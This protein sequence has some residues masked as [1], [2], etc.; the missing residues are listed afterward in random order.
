MN[1]KAITA[2]VVGLVIGFILG[3]FVARGPGNSDATTPSNVAS[4]NGAEMPEGHP[5][6]EVIRKLAEL[7]SRATSNPQ[8][9]EVR[10]FLGNFYYDIGRYDGAIRWYEEALELDPTDVNVSTDLGT[11]YL[12]VGNTDRAIEVYKKSLSL[13]PNHPQTLQNLGIAYSNIEKF[14]EAAETWNRLIENHPEHP[15]IGRLKEQIEEARQ[16][17]QGKL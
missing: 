11:S 8:D 9:R 2:G 4:T 5:P 16:R 14:A 13:Q 3:F 1:E 10:I 6:V 15:E 17:A 12:H 7:Q